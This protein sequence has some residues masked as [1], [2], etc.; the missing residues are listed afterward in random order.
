MFVV[1]K[2]FFTTEFILLAELI[3]HRGIIIKCDNLLFL[4]RVFFF[5]SGKFTL[6]EAK[7]VESLDDVFVIPRR[8]SLAITTI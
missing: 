5:I 4:R 3:I 7:K 2:G 1:I 8:V 6:E